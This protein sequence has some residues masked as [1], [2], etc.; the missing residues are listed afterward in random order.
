MR[1]FNIVC[2]FC[3]NF[4]PFPENFDEIH[5]CQCGAVYKITWQSDMEDSM[6]QLTDFFLKDGGSSRNRLENNILC[7]AV[8]YED[9]QDLIRMKTEY[10]AAKYIRRIQ[11]FDQDFPQKVGLVWLGNYKAE[12]LYF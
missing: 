8:V 9:I 12:H 7:H 1:S 11:S 3:E 2:P 4:Y 5:R 10:E 6:N